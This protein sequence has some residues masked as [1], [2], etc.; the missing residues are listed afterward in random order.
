MRNHLGE[1]K[2]RDRE[3][4]RVL[5]LDIIK[6]KVF[7]QNGGSPNVLTSRCVI[8]SIGFVITNRTAHEVQDPGVAFVQRPFGLRESQSGTV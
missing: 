3:G 7:M 4:K 6:R 2:F 8:L 1:G 5:W